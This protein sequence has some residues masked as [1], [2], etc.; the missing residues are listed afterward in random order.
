M[1]D[2]NVER[3]L[4][5]TRFTWAWI[6]LGILLLG[7]LAWLVFGFWGMASGPQPPPVELTPVSVLHRAGWTV[8]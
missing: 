5:G 7:A 1:A 2:L 4:R 8:G 3:R 6:G